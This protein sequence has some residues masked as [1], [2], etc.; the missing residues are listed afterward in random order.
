MADR[1]GPGG[2]IANLIVVEQAAAFGIRITFRAH[3]AAGI[4]VVL[5]SLAILLIW[6][7]L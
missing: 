4:P 2:G 3:A 5:L 1:Q 6:I 7:A